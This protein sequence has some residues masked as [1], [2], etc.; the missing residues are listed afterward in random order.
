MQP[1]E[2]HWRKSSEEVKLKM[3]SLE[4]WR[5]AKTFITT[6]FLSRNFPTQF[7]QTF[8]YMS[9]LCSQDDLCFQGYLRHMASCSSPAPISVAEQELQRIKVTEVKLN[10]SSQLWWMNAMVWVC[11]TA[12]ACY[13][14]W[15]LQ[16]KVLQVCLLMLIQLCVLL[17]ETRFWTFSGVPR[18]IVD[19]LGLQLHEHGCGNTRFGGILL[20]P[21]WPFP[22][23][24]STLMSLRSPWS[25]AWT[26]V[27]RLSKVLHSHC[28]KRPKEL[29]SNSNR[30]AS[31]IYSWWAGTENLITH[32]NAYSINKTPK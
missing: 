27:H 12:D 19:D 1:L 14:L 9:N 11:Y 4:L 7:D 30:D 20:F 25:L 21:Y 13:F 26:S 23:F 10:Q 32:K 2:P 17:L 16:D 24:P 29:C 15:F 8:C 5:L 6:L 3:K 28:R 18:R 22:V 31:T